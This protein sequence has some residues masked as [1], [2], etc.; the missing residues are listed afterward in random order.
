M[1]ANAVRCLCAVCILLFTTLPF[2][3]RAF[4]LVNDHQNG[5]EI[6]SSFVYP[7]PHKDKAMELPMP[8]NDCY[9]KGNNWILRTELFGK[10]EKEITGRFPVE[11]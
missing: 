7:V 5:T 8:K 9:R 4:S 1:K 10:N 3:A 11:K 6:S 2:L